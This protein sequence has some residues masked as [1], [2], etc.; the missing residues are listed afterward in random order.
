[1]GDY[2][3]EFINYINDIL[4]AE[5]NRHYRIYNCDPY[6]KRYFD[7]QRHRLHIY[8]LSKRE[9]KVINVY[10][11]KLCV[12]YNIAETFAERRRIRE[13][14]RELFDVLLA[15][16]REMGGDYEESTDISEEE[17]HP[18]RW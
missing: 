8:N 16:I 11:G 7:R 9:N 3:D 13:L 4:P 17:D 6:F 12:A 5:P 18:D 1:M 10:M 2:F 14:T 15:R